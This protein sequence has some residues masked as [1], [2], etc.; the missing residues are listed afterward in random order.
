LE[1]IITKYDNIFDI[2]IIDDNDSVNDEIHNQI[3]KIVSKSPLIHLE[4]GFGS[5][6]LYDDNEGI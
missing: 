2:G 3:Y 1:L 6:S 5:G 4:F